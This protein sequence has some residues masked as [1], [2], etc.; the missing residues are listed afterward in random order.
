MTKLRVPES[1]EDALIQ[2]ESFVTREAVA[3]Y[4]GRSP[5]LVQ[6]FGDP[7]TDQQLQLR[8]A[9]EID[10]CLA[11]EGY[12]QPFAALFAA[13]AAR[14]ATAGQQ[15]ERALATEERPMRL[16]VAA[17]RDAAKIVGDLELA[18]ADGVYTAAEVAAL[19]RQL[20]SLQKQV[21]DLK[22]GIARRGR[23]T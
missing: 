9:L 21:A 8:Q 23:R 16:A 20:T 22:Q 18:E 3:R 12:P 10:R 1:I 5:A 4:I 19:L 14:N 13:R 2:A 7:D 15:L 6:K 11:L 17:V